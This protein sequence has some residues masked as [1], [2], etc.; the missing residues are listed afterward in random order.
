MP[1]KPR[2]YLPDVPAHIV[3]RG[4][5]RDP[6]LF[7][8]DDYRFYL[9]CLSQAL[10]R[11]KVR[12]HA[13]VLM[14]NHVHLLLT[15]NSTDGISKVMSLLG[16]Q[17]VMYINHTY[18]RSGTLWE[19]RHK[20]SIVD[21]QDYLLTCYRY[22]ELNPVRAGMVRNPEDY[23]WSS[24]GHNACHRTDPLIEDHEIYLGLGGTPDE[25]SRYYRA[26]FENK[27]NNKDLEAIRYSSH[28]N[29]LLGNDRFKDK[30]E[31]T[32]NRKV[33]Y[34]KRGRPLRGGVNGQN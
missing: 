21:A 27:L 16:Q 13:Y 18:R 31:R 30:I 12:L 11:Y 19:G 28:C 14:T 25:C 15:P 5:N 29:Y 17:Y 9:N 26:M 6:T 2:M 23:L 33:G 8:E 4:N 32:L 20:A 3:Q 10:K 1:R 7:A 22:I 24:Y 34:A